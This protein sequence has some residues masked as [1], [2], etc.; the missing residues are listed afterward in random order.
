[1]QIFQHRTFLRAAPYLSLLNFE[2]FQVFKL[3]II[4]WPLRCTFVW[5]GGEAALL[6][7]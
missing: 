1:M 5:W 7:P 6:S 3:E 2:A 4:P